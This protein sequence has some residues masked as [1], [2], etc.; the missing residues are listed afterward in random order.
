MTFPPGSNERADLEA[1]KFLKE[2][3]Q[4]LG[5]KGMSSDSEGTCTVRGVPHQVYFV[6]VI[7][8]RAEK[9]SEYM[10]IVDKEGLEPHVTNG[11]GPRPNPRIRNVREVTAHK[12][13]DKVVSKREDVVV[14]L[15]KA[16][17]NANWVAEKAME[18]PDFE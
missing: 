14:G 1:W 7:P 9:I 18:Y 3:I 11:R 17:Y 6:R 15:P 8:W 13:A 12:G 5:V 4:M 2:L 10:G 16:V